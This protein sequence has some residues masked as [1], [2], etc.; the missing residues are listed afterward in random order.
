MN[1]IETAKI[2]LVVNYQHYEMKWCNVRENSRDC[3]ELTKNTL[4]NIKSTP[5]YCHK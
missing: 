2:M 3:Y 5:Q 1:G 4:Y